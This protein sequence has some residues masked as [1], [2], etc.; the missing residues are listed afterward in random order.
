MIRESVII[1][2]AIL[3]LLLL[4]S[5]AFVCEHKIQAN[6]HQNYLENNLQRFSGVSYPYNIWAKN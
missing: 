6:A 1:M 2:L 4:M 3:T 5:F